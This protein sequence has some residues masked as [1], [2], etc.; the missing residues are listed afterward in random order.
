MKNTYAIVLTPDDT[1]YSVYIPDFDIGTQ[2]E[3]L[4]EAIEMARDA[5]GMMGIDM[6][7]DK[8]EIPMPSDISEIKLEDG[9]IKT[10]V[11][12]DFAE[13]RRQNDMR[14]VKKNCTLPSWL[15]A[16]AEKAGINFSAVLQNALKVE[17]GVLPTELKGGL[18]GHDISAN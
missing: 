2:G 7:D 9:E 8:E 6:E 3:N 5:I 14:M 16:R 4:T 11:D 17:L 10:L 15:N 13:Y 1:G 12:V 18:V